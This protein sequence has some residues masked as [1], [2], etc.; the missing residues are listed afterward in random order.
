M[1]N[2]P[3]KLV[4]QNGATPATG[5][6]ATP[7][8]VKVR[9]YQGMD[10]DQPFEIEDPSGA[11]VAVSTFASIVVT[12]RESAGDTAALIGT[13][14]NY[15]AEGSNGR[16]EF[17]NAETKTFKVGKLDIVGTTPDGK[18][19]PL[20]D[21]DSDLDYRDMCHD[22]AATVT[23]PPTSFGTVLKS[24]AVKTSNYIAAIGEL[25]LVDPSAGAFTVT[26]PTLVG[27]KDALVGVKHVSN[28]ANL[29]TVDGN[30]SE[31]IDGALAMT[32]GSRECLIIQSD[33]ANGMV[34]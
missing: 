5:V 6:E 24:T 21:P 26:L 30:A 11:D 25:V 23:G 10:V 7:P 12:L 18:K 1:R 13:P 32:V 20:C 4:Y 2:A 22:S 16:F 14:H 27:V 33:N 8:K 17:T 29:V 34:I 31:T 28:S 9:I 3:I 15:F 19:H